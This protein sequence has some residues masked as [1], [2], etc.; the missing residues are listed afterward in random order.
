MR[1]YLVDII[2]HTL[3][4]G[5]FDAL[6]IDGDTSETSVSATEVNRLLVLRAKLNKPL[7]DL[8]GTF[9][10][11]NIGL[12]NTIL[13]I[14][15]Y[16]KDAKIAMNYKD[17]NGTQVPFNIHFENEN[18]DFKNDFRLIGK[19]VI[20]SKEPTTKML[21]DKWPV[22]FEPSVSAMQRYKY[23]LSANPDEKTAEFTVKDG[24]VK[25]SLGD[26]TSNSGSYEF[27]SGVDNKLNYGVS[28]SSGFLASIFTLTGDKTINIG[29]FGMM[30][31][32]NSGLAT[33]NYVLPTISK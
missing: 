11:P 27:H 4:L 23:Q 25:A 17:D 29:D 30:V 33:Y 2:K 15:E 10:I 3:P 26:N 1:D 9:G 16:E 6:R 7:K 18:G 24:A 8:E 31:T 19:K 22:S 20:D 12:L 13:S 5:A 32:V 21:I 28:V 14:P